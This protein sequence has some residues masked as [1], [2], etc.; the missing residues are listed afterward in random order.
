MKPWFGPKRWGIGLSPRSW[1]GWLLTVAV[2]LGVG[3]SGTMGGLESWQHGAIIG[4][5][6]AAY[7]AMAFMTFGSRPKR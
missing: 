1:E 7:L 6:V 5:L 3:F 2:V 4:G